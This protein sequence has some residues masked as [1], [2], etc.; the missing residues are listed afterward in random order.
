MRS[1]ELAPRDGDQALYPLLD[2]LLEE[3]REPAVLQDQLQHL[4]ACLLELSDGFSPP[5]LGRFCFF[6]ELALKL[7]HLFGGL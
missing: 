3:V 4:A 1:V 7:S 6:F 5:L 2:R